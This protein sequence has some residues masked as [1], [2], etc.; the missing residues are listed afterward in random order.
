MTWE[1]S[2]TTC[3]NLALLAFFG[4]DDKLIL[5]GRRTVALKLSARLE[6]GPV[7]RVRQALAGFLTALADQLPGPAQASVTLGGLATGA[8][9]NQCR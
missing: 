9:R 2:E 8:H 7:E 3:C 6:S 4:A 5:G 1:S